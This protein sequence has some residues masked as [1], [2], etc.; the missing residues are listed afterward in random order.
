MAYDV[1]EFRAAGGSSVLPTK[2]R[3]SRQV[4]PNVVVDNGGIEVPLSLDRA[5]VLAMIDPDAQLTER[6][7]YSELLAGF[8]ERGVL[9]TLAQFDPSSWHHPVPP[10]EMLPFNECE[11]SI[12]QNEHTGALQRA[13]HRHGA[14]LS[15]QGP[16]SRTSLIA[17]PPTAGSGPFLVP[18]TGRR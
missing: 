17:M 9:D 5:V 13:V 3:T 11:V 15:R 8:S 1:S 4:L 14:S 12:A 16:P 6:D 10:A 2:G 7:V 18:W